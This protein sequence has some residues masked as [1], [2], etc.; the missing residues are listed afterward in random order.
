MLLISKTEA[1]VDTLS[2]GEI[3][4]TSLLRGAC[5][6]YEPGAEDRKIKLSCIVPDNMRLSGDSRMIQRMLANLLDNAIKY[7]PPGGRVDI[8][9]STTAAGQVVI[10]VADTGIG[11]AAN[12]QP[13]VFERFYRGDQ[14]RSASGIGLG[15]SLARAIA[16]AHGGDITVKSAPGAGS[17][18][19]AAL[20]ARSDGRA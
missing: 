9:A 8:S 5:E 20:P 7:T 1:G 10:S 14:S 6:L 16:R 18:F 12:D 2:I 13:R 11:I 17:T 3:D 15:L 19:T 4:L